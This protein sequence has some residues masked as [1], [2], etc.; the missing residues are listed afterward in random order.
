[1]MSHPMNQCVGILVENACF[2]FGTA[3]LIHTGDTPMPDWG[4]MY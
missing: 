4:I 2:Q 1:M 3:I